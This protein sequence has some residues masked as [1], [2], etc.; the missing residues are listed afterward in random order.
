MNVRSTELGAAL[1]EMHERAQRLLAGG[2]AAGARALLERL[3]TAAPAHVPYWLAFAAALRRLGQR[4]EEL[5][6]LERALALDPTHPVV[7]LQKGSVLDLLN[8]PRAAAAAYAHALQAVTP[9]TRMPA[10][11]EAHVAHARTRVAENAAKL[12]SLIDARLSA[13]STTPSKEER[14]RFDRC[15]DRLLGRARIYTPDPTFMLFPY[16][17]NYEF[18]PREFFPWLETLEAF[19]DEIRAELLAVLGA[20]RDGVVPYIDYAAGLPLNQWRELNHSRRWGAYFLWNEG[21][22]LESHLARCPRTEKALAA[23]PQVDIPGRGPTAFF[24]LLDARTKIPP[25]TGVTNTRLTVHLPLIVPPGCRFRV[26]GE[27]REW[28]VG[29]GWV[30]DDTIEHEAW[31]DSDVT[32]AI[33]IFD[34]WNP[35]LTPLERAFVRE[36]TVVIAE[37]SDAETGVA[38]A[39]H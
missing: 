9:G 28:S 2:D 31:N 1:E 10:P 24:S 29:T 38:G 35:Q 30:F 7:L 20:D 26:G 12:A 11:I 6:A 36:A 23:L 14:K 13:L 19:T 17:I 15:L 18:F 8:K 32:R 21:Q 22:R 25:H 3:V 37:Y 4:A 27:I 16:L 33:L 34:V 39:P 5:A